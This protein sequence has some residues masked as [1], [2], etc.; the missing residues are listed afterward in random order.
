MLVV[1]VVVVVRSVQPD[2]AQDKLE[3]TGDKLVTGDVLLGATR[4]A[5]CCP[6]EHENEENEQGELSNALLPVM[7]VS[8][9]ARPSSAQISSSRR[10]D[11]IT[12]VPLVPL[13]PGRANCTQARS[14]AAMWCEVGWKQRTENRTAHW[15]RGNCGAEQRLDLTTTLCIRATGL[16]Q[17]IVP[18]TTLRTS[19]NM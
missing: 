12:L 7:L 1:V 9:A 8:A 6:H 4:C 3:S 14:Q 18:D 17:C 19:R 2:G 11:H 5:S 16:T 10:N 13:V 15:S